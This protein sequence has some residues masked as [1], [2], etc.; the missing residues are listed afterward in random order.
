M[1]HPLVTQFLIPVLIRFFFVFGIIGFAV[2]VGLIVN[3]VRM[4]RLFGIMNRWVSM[5]RSTK[6]LSIPRDTGPFV[7]RFRRLIG[8][9]FVLVA[10]FST[11][12]MITQLDAHRIVAALGVDIPYPLAMWIV[13]SLRWILIVGSMV[14]I[15]VG[16][17]L[18]FFPNVMQAV[19]TR[20]DHWYSTRSHSR[21]ADTMHMGF[22]KL[23]ENYPRAMGWI[24]AA[25]SFVVVIHY[26]IWLFARS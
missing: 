14:A 22:D 11:F 3:R 6:W 21:A 15:G 1:N 12:V 2:G 10:A 26:G 25:A 17:M 5:R 7:Q 18:I 9:T 16:I 13:E 23:V 24:I 20:A 8:T 19:E 4:L